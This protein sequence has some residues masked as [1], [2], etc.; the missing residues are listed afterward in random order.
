MA[1]RDLELRVR[2]NFLGVLRMPVSGGHRVLLILRLDVQA[3]ESK[4]SR[5]EIAPMALPV[6]SSQVIPEQQV[7]EDTQKMMANALS[8]GVLPQDGDAFEMINRQV[9][10]LTETLGA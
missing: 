8:V 7:A 2:S 6:W 3:L 4:T 5:S 9:A 10:Q 1:E